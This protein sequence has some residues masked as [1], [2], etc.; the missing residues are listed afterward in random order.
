MIRVV[1]YLIAIGILAAGIAW[2][3]D[4]P[5]EVNVTWLGW[6]IETSVMVAAF[7]VAALTALLMLAW[8]LLRGIV[9]APDLLSMFL[10]RRRG[11]KGYLAISRGLIAVGTGDTRIARKFAH[12]ARRLAPA[13]P[14]ALLL[15]AQSAQL[16][17]DRVAAER[18]FAEMTR[19]PDTKLL[20]L[21]GLFIEA[22]RREDMVA[23][24]AYAEEAAKSGPSPAWAGQAVLEFRCAAGDWT[25]ALA[26]LEKNMRSGLID[27]P[28]YRRQRAVLLTAQ[29][30]KAEETDRDGAK[31]LALEA[32]KLAPTLVPAAAL[33]GRFLAEAGELRKAGRILNRAWQANPHPDIAETFAHLRFGDSARDRLVRVETLAQKAPGNIEGAL[34]LSCAALG[35][36]EF[37]K[38]RTALSP[39]ITAP[40]QRVALVM[41]EI[42]EIEH[43][44]NGRARE[45]MARAVHAARDPAWTADGFIS[46][47]WLPVSPVS[48]RLD[49]FQW[50]V[51]L[52]ELGGPEAGQGSEKRPALLDASP[53]KPTPA[54]EEPAIEQKPV[55]EIKQERVAAEDL[56]A[57]R[58]ADA[59]PARKPK[60]EAVIPLVHVPD[61]PGPEADPE[62]EPIPEPSPDRWD[63]LRQFLK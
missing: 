10:R 52:A 44:D 30:L 13:E 43:G 40:T 58:A 53:K 35:A 22:R 31:A 48:G 50:K 39:F 15:G 7:A 41:A 63:K 56:P 59:K 54:A 45:W 33:A 34:A 3:A 61:D 2:L 18:A 47:R 55:A 11:K 46:E 19:R 23:A 51:P 27:R 6:R 25:G 17:G 38:A 12:E 49:A 36:R 16:S 42:E 29:A 37:T 1:L 26:A 8:S 4:R 32:V 24:R 21:R 9:R 60:V 5:G 14:L 57:G 28:T 62:P 20:G